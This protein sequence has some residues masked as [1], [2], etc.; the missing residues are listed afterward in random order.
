MF[1]GDILFHRCTPDRLGGHVRQL[2]RR[3]RAHSRRST[4]ATVVPGHGPMADVDGLRGLREY[5]EYVRDRRAGEL[6]G[7]PHHARGRRAHRPRPLC[8][9]WT[10]PERLAFQV[11]RAYREFE[12][13]AWDTPV[14]T[15]R[16]FGEV[17][18]L[19][20]RYAASA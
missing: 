7:R 20:E 3:A 11:D 12:G 18:A 19:R 9:L 15:N 4:P 1:T 16:V 2:D 17:A 5:L 13:V 6:R 14:D 10:E 8:G